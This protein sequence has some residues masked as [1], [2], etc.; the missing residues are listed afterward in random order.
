MM[1][2]R[3]NFKYFSES[4]EG[5][6]K[7]ILQNVSA[8][9]HKRLIKILPPFPSKLEYIA[10]FLFFLLPTYSIYLGWHSSLW[11]NCGFFHN[12]KC[13]TWGRVFFQLLPRSRSRSC[14]FKSKYPKLVCGIVARIPGEIS[15]EGIELCKKY[16][17]ICKIF[18]LW[19]CRCPWRKGCTS[20]NN[21]W[22]KRIGNLLCVYEILCLQNKKISRKSIYSFLFSDMCHSETS[23]FCT[24]AILHS[25]LI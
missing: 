18:T 8:Y 23:Y 24:F 22:N 6:K 2:R 1:H 17:E 15:R 5:N 11:C 13:Q 12:E 3:S 10:P 4:R 14:M 19:S 16:C 21:L 25:I 20:L 9:V 7:T